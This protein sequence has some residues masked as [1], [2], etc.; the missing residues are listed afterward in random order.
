MSNAR[1]PAVAL[2]PLI[3]RT[4]TRAERIA[5]DLAVTAGVPTGFASGEKALQL[6]A[7]CD[8]LARALLASFGD[9]GEHEPAPA[10]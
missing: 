9:G 1:T 6:A 2:Y 7:D 10:R 3:R 4:V 8:E 5:Y